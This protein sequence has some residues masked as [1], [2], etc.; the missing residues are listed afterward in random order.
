MQ[1]TAQPQKY[2]A[3]VDKTKKK[4]RKKRKIYNHKKIF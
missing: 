4:N 1:L 2:K 3:H